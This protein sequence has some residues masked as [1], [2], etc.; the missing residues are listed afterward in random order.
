MNHVDIVMIESYL[1]CQIFFHSSFVP[2][3]IQTFFW[4]QYILW[5]KEFVFFLFNIYWCYSSIENINI[6]PFSNINCIF[7][8]NYLLSN[9]IFKYW[10]FL[11]VPIHCLYNFEFMYSVLSLFMQM[12]ISFVFSTKN[13]FIWNR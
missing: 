6:L 12:R 2:R 10:Y 3:L 5:S 11:F 7:F 4:I 8:E 9:L 13:L 1:A